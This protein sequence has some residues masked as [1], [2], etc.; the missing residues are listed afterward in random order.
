MTK[1]TYSTG[2][3]FT[4]AHKAVRSQIYLVLEE[5]D[6][7]PSHWFVLGSAM[8]A[9]TG[10]RLTNVAKQMDVK[11]PLVTMLANELIEMGL[12]TRVQ[13]KTDKR[14]KL[15]KATA[16]GKK[17]ARRIENDLAFKIAQLLQ[18]A[19]LAQIS[20]FQSVLEIILK[21]AEIAYA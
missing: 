14:A 19:S 16:N 11:A 8:Q 4:Q 18:G 12:I 13:H 6:I 17:L 5:Y 21:N 3:L 7:S 1:A 9:S 20:N 2:M 15:L 10:I